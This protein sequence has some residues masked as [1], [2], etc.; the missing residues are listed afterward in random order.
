M[1]ALPP[2]FL[3]E[4]TMNTIRSRR[5]LLAGAPVAA[6]AALAGGTVAN[7][8]AIAMSKAPVNPDD[9]DAKLIELAL[10]IFDLAPDVDASVV[11]VQRSDSQTARATMVR[12]GMDPD[13]PGARFADKETEAGELERRMAVWREVR[14]G[15]G[16]S[17]IEEEHDRIQAL[18][19]RLFEEMLELPI[20]TVRGA[21]LVGVCSIVTGAISHYW[22]ED[23]DE[24]DWPERVIRLLIE[25][26][27]VGAT[28]QSPAIFEK[29]VRA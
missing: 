7:A 17:R 29:L 3:Q 27:H 2:A 28:G 15:L 8:V 6:A 22:H 24:L 26:L 18:S 14:E 9:P 1:P 25:N 23:I 12:L 13:A 10:Q 4:N 20:R 11:A 19:D 5:A 21:A 16:N